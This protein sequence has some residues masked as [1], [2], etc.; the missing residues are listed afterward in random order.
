MKKVLLNRLKSL[1]NKIQNFL[2]KTKTLIKENPFPFIYVFGATINGLLVRC[3][4]TK[5]IFTI[6][7]L[8][9]DLFISLIFASLYFVIKKKYRKVY[10]WLVIIISTIVCIGNI[11]YYSYYE[12][13]ISVT[14]ISFA[15]TNTETG[16]SNVVGD[17]LKL[18]YFI[19][20][21]FP[22]SMIGAE[23][24]I[25]RYN[26]KRNVEEQAPRV[27]RKKSL[28]IIYI[29]VLIFATAFLATLKSI[30]YSRFYKQWNREYLVNRFG[31]YLYQLNDVVKSLEPTMASLFGTDKAM[32]EVDDYFKDTSDTKDYTNE[33]TN[34]FKGKNVIAIHAESMHNLIDLSFNGQDVTPNLKKLSNEGL[35][36]SNFYSQVSF[37]TSS[38]TEFT[39]ATSLL[40]V[41]SGTVFINYFD[42]EYK[43][44]YKL[45]QEKG[46]YTFSMHANTGDFW[47]RN[48]MYKAL[49][50]SKFYEKSSFNIDETIGFG[51]SDKS[52]VTQAVEK[53]KKINSENKNFYGTLITLSNHTP[54]DEVESYGTY[55]VSKTVDGV[56]YDYLEGTKLGNYMKSAHYA[57]EQIGLLIKLLDE[58]GI[59]DNTII[60]IYG[61]HDARISKSEWNYMYNYD[62]KTNTVLDETDPNYKEIDYYWYELNRRVPL[63]IWSK[64]ETFKT[65]YGKEITTAMGMYDVSPT[66]GNMLGIYNKYALGTDIMN[67][68]DDNL[69]A[70]PNGNF[71]TN[72]VYYSDSKEEYKLLT[73]KALKEN[74]IEEN[75][76][77]AEKKLKISNDIIIYDYFKKKEESLNYNKEK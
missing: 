24:A 39:L 67:K 3:L 59:L 52:F 49:G 12:S 21:W 9:A 62:P 76:I 41:D 44:M 36:F 40:P 57:D 17:L 11:V 75:K 18:K 60:M 29:W 25:R 37:G 51:L 38:D 71:L 74:Y 43:S 73:E 65:Q 28:R 53:I 72:Y 46:Y 5:K 77:E 68:Q 48:I 1:K 69:V 22:I 32:K 4:T 6:S 27:Y 58:A 47:N 15:L 20:L 33:Y 2:N 19:I 10:I 55:D 30:D 16:N 34:I 35:Y 66:L 45:L 70:F 42:R 63:I 50:Y 8:L 13:F 61:D 26:K 64:D 31:V 7:P 56:K 14:F 54:F 23:I